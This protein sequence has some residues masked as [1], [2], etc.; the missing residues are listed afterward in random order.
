MKTKTIVITGALASSRSRENT[1]T[2]FVQ[3]ALNNKTTDIQTFGCMQVSKAILAVNDAVDDGFNVLVVAKSL[4]A[5]RFWKRAD[6]L[7]LSRYVGM[8]STEPPRIS[9][10]LIDPHFLAFERLENYE[11]FDTA[12]AKCYYQRDKYPRGAY[13]PHRSTQLHNTDHFAIADMT[14]DA[15]RIVADYVRAEF[16]RLER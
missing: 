12:V 16:V 5:Y 3:L 15:G 14:T 11:T 1:I 10:V 6:K 2:N 8:F 13:I 9:I 4:G 7:R